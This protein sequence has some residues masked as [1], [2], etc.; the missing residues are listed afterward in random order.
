MTGEALW[1][2]LGTNAHLLV[3]NGDVDAGREAVEETLAE[4]DATYSRFRP[5][6]ELVG[7]NARSGETVPV[8]P[9]LA[10]A[11]G[12][13]L[14]AAMLT[15]GLADPTVGRALRATGYDRDFRLIESEADAPVVRL[16]TVP[17]WRAVHLDARADT[18][19]LQRGVEL[20]LDATGK[21]LA[22]ELGAAAA[23]TRLGPSAASSCPSA[24]TSRWS[25]R[26][27]P[28]AGR[29]RSRRT[30]ARTRRRAPKSSPSRPAVS[31]RR[32]RPCVAGG[33]AERSCITSWTRG[34]AC[35]R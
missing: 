7:L 19:R 12:V 25:A 24:A 27:R 35:P 21:A 18:V 14:R 23:A 20:D 4:V 3:A 29:S 9:L 31:P 8:S 28:A 1:S 33:T 2:A 17:G 15:D 5:D 30:A 22:A 32:A 16:E 34:P 26:R 11:I 13:A 10:R 6:S